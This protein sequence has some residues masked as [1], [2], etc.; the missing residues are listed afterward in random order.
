MRVSRSLSLLGLLLVI[1]TFVGCAFWNSDNEVLNGFLSTTETTGAAAVKFRVVMPDSSGSSKPTA[2]I[3]Q[4]TSPASGATVVFRLT[5]IDA[6]TNRVDTLL[7]TVTVNASGTAETSFSGV[8]AKTTI[9]E[10]Q[11]Q[12]GAIGGKTD[13]HGAADLLNGENILD[14]SPKGCG[15]RA[16]VVANVL[17]LMI[18]AGDLLTGAP[19]NLVSAIETAGAARLASPTTTLYNDV[20]NDFITTRADLPGMIKLTRNL[21]GASLTA[22]GNATWTKTAGDLWGGTA[23]AGG[24]SI[25]RVLRQGIAG[26]AYV[27]LANPDQTSFA[28][29]RVSTSDGRVSAYVTGP[30]R[31]GS[32][33]FLPNGH[34]VVGGSLAGSP[35][36]FR[37][38]GTNSVTL[39][40]SAV[41]GGTTTGLMW[42]QRFEAPGLGFTNDFVPTAPPVEYLEVES[43]QTKTLLCHARDPKTRVLK[44]LRLDLDTGSPN[45]VPTISGLRLWAQPGPSEIIVDWDALPDIATYTLTWATGPGVLATGTQIV[46][47]TKPFRHTALDPDLTYYY[48]VSWV[49]G[50]GQTQV[51]PVVSTKPINGAVRGGL[52]DLTGTIVLPAGVTYATSSLQI[53]SN[54]A[55]ATVTTNRTFVLS[56]YRPMTEGAMSLGIVVNQNEKPVLL[57]YFRRG[58]DDV[59]T[60]IDASSTAEAMVLSD[61]TYR[62]MGTATIT[63]I[64]RQLRSHQSFPI[65]VQAVTTSIASF[66][67][68][69]LNTSTQQTLWSQAASLSKALLAQTPSGTIRQSIA[70]ESKL[71]VDDDPEQNKPT[72][73]LINKFYTFYFVGVK[74]GNDSNVATSSLGR[75]RDFAPNGRTE[76]EV[77]IGDGQLTFTFQKRRDLSIFAAIVDWAAKTME[78]GFDENKMEELFKTGQRISDPAFWSFLTTACS[79]SCSTNAEATLL[80][81]SW[82]ANSGETIRNFIGKLIFNDYQMNSGW[83][84]FSCEFESFHGIPVGVHPVSSIFDTLNA[85]PENY[86]EDGEQKNGKYPYYSP[87]HE[88]VATQMK[89]QLVWPVDLEANRTIYNNFDSAYP[90]E[91]V[92]SPTLW[93]QKVWSFGDGSTSSETYP[94]HAYSSPGSYK[95]TLTNSY[96]T[97]AGQEITRVYTNISV[98]PYTNLLFQVVLLDSTGASLGFASSFTVTIYHNDEFFTR[99]EKYY[100]GGSNNWSWLTNYS[101]PLLRIPENDCSFALDVLDS[102]YSTGFCIGDLTSISNPFGA[103]RASNLSIYP[104]ASSP[105]EFTIKMLAGENQLLLNPPIIID[106]TIFQKILSKHTLNQIKA[107]AGKSKF[108]ETEDILELIRSTTQIPKEPQGNSQYKFQ[109]VK[110]FDRVIGFDKVTGTGTNIITVITN[111]SDVLITAH[112]GLPNKY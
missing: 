13:F 27:A 111:A 11:I 99:A 53:W 102:T 70:P 6:R 38:D 37:W 63:E 12:G 112:P 97:A 31:F 16:D 87:F 68:D 104:P 79:G 98:L 94:V 110:Y 60:V 4:A 14:V 75:M 100:Q 59:N 106:Q 78:F 35:L 69:P 66:P 84:R 48:R 30:G 95:V 1:A 36:V 45:L 41:S 80:L 26:F 81:K 2:A 91:F 92:S 86:A 3:L 77:N 21:D 52:G 22:S 76:K 5:I 67:L 58:L 34:V 50:Q 73:Y 105:R 46:G 49:D 57:K 28:V 29:V 33:V 54:I 17:K 103:I 9:G 85:A 42:L 96:G 20:L 43:A 65:L 18:N 8:P 47:V 83:F 39:S 82:F 40:S 108:A 101:N 62:Y 89:H 24:A 90:V 109:R 10:I 15:L 64:L 72:V 71:G 88:I 74:N 107:F 44:V 25:L 19:A 32:A 55:S 56:V 23:P 7:K 61:L 51:S 93:G